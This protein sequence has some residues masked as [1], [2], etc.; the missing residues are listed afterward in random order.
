MRP[1]VLDRLEQ[2]IERA[3][4]GTVA[5]FFRL[6]VQPADIGRQL[7]RAMVGRRLSSVGAVLVPNHYEVRVHPDDAAAFTGW[8]NALCH[9]METWLADV[10]YEQGLA[11]LGPIRVTI[12]GDDTVA[13]RSVRASSSFVD[14]VSPA[15]SR[16]ESAG[17]ALRLVPVKRSGMEIALRDRA[18]TVGRSESNDHVLADAEV[19]RRH[20]RIEPD[21]GGRGWRVVDLGSTNG[22][23]VNGTR[24]ERAAISSGDL[25]AFG[26]VSFQVQ[27]YGRSDH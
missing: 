21:R 23:W 4:E 1:D 8:E 14:V 6:R 20:A 11:T 9:E 22:T 3:V 25:I 27:P 12:L 17:T 10:A 19:S 26:S 5:G 15:L 13:R 16:T 18:V 7:E 2:A 24:V